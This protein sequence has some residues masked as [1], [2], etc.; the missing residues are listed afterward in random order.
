MSPQPDDIHERLRAMSRRGAPLSLGE[1]QDREPIPGLRPA[2]ALDRLRRPVVAVA[3]LLLIVAAAVVTTRGL[4]G[5]QVVSVG[6]SGTTTQPTAPGPSGPSDPP[7]GPPATDPP[8]AATSEPPAPLPSGSTTRTVVPPLT[9]LPSAPPTS[10]TPSTTTTA[11]VTSTAVATPTPTC[12]I[13]AGLQ[14]ELGN[15]GGGAGN[16]EQVVVFTNRTP[17]ACT[18]AGWPGVS[19]LDPAGQQLGPAADRSEPAT[20]SRTLL[21]PVGGTA[22]VVILT[23]VNELYAGPDCG[24]LVTASVRIY[25]PDDTASVILA[26]PGPV[27][28]TGIVPLHVSAVATGADEPGPAG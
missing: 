24:E 25:P 6:T 2:A 10:P 7:A 4:R 9:T 11:A 3:L 28:S 12:A 13:G 27:C 22:H 14:V 17:R 8:S 23:R 21:L 16:R 26:W 5:D 1:V 15:A 19:L 18:I 20:G